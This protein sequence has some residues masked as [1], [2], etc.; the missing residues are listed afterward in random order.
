MLWSG[1]DGW[2]HLVGH[3]T[4]SAKQSWI[5]APELSPKHKQHWDLGI[6]P[7]DPHKNKIETFQGKVLVLPHF[8]NMHQAFVVLSLNSLKF[9]VKHKFPPRMQ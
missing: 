9:S 1:A 5:F 7:L 6:S 2:V 4:A 8:Q 3:L